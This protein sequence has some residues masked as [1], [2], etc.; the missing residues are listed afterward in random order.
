MIHTVY[1]KEDDMTFIT[2]RTKNT[3]SVIGFYFSELNED[4]T[5]FYKYKDLT[6]VFA[7]EEK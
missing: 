1:A 4:D 5:E 3:F 6:T 2:E 7:E